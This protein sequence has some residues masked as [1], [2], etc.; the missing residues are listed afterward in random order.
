MKYVEKLGLMMV[1]LGIAGA[2]SISI[3]NMIL[4]IDDPILLPLAI[5]AVGA[6]LYLLFGKEEE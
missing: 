1:I 3:T 5:T 4:S 6:T 2:M